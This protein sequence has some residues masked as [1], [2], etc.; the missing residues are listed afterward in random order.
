MIPLSDA[1]IGFACRGSMQMRDVGTLIVNRDLL[2]W[3]RASDDELRHSRACRSCPTEPD[4]AEH[5]RPAEPSDLQ[6]K[7]L[8]PSS[9]L[10]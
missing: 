6:A 5:H 1:T 9:Y 8:K 10:R 4:P 3:V 7:R 2:D